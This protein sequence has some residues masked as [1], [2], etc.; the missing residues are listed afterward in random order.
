MSRVI[1]HVARRDGKNFYFGSI[2]AMCNSGILEGYSQNKL[3]NH[4]KDEGEL[5]LPFLGIIIFRGDLQTTGDVKKQ[6]QKRV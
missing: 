4:F 5:V 6:A 3:Y 1:Y 2:Q